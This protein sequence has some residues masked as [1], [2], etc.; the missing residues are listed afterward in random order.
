VKRPVK[1]SV[2]ILVWVIF[3]GFLWFCWAWTQSEASTGAFA[4]VQ[5]GDSEGQVLT[6][7]GKPFQITGPAS[8][9]AWDS[10]GSL[11]PNHGEC[12]REFWYAPRLQIA[13]EKW[14]IGFDVHSNVV[15][16]YRYE[17]P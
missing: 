8:N 15:S 6:L 13:G 7:L 3:L 11:R 5:R 16:K 4:R 9:V 10:D 1:I 17:S 2:M 14:A 12:V